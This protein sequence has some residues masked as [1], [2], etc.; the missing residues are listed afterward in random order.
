[1]PAFSTQQ[2]VEYFPGE[3]VRATFTFRQKDTLQKK[4]PTT[5]TVSVVDPDGN[6]KDYEWGTDSEVVRD[7]EGVFVFR[8]IYSL[9][10]PKGIY[11]IRANGTGI[12]ETA[13]EA[14][15]ALRNS[16]FK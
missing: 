8:K 1:M 13:I 5:V 2:P 9:D 4:D 12:L 16:D 15:F 7:S 11:Q 6:Q 10:D 3:Q 14:V